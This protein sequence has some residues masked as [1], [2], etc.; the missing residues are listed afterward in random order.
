MFTPIA[1]S[2]VAMVP[3]T[4]NRPDRRPGRS[5]N[6]DSHLSSVHTSVRNRRMYFSF[7][8]RSGG[9]YVFPCIGASLCNAYLLYADG[10]GL[11][12]ISLGLALE[13]PTTDSHRT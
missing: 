6:D 10:S 1:T 8:R 11:R 4:N 3:R 9:E 12:S 7:A 2:G 13:Q 5:R